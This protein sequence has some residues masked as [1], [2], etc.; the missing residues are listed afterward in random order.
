MSDEP[1][2]RWPDRLA[3][4]KAAGRFY[5]IVFGLAAIMLVVARLVISP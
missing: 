2:Q 1:N 5:L 3:L 4:L